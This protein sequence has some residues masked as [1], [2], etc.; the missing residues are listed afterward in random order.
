MISLGGTPIVGFGESVTVP[1]KTG[2]SPWPLA[3]ATSVVGAA[4]GW[5]IEEVA[6]S[7]RKKRR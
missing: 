5:V 3:L 7:V 4:A 1:I 2:A 6:R